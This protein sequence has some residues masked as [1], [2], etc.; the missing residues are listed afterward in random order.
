M[1]K[2]NIS[3]KGIWEIPKVLLGL[4]VLGGCFRAGCGC[5]QDLYQQR[6]EENEFDKKTLATL[7]DKKIM[8]DNGK[9]HVIIWLDTNNDLVTAEGFCNMPDAKPEKALEIYNI[10]N[11]TTKSVAE[12]KQITRPY[13]IHLC[14]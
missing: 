4:F 2:M 1:K 9:N 11:R 3:K 10:T 8:G 6:K 7:I 14:K 12:W 13:K 5:S